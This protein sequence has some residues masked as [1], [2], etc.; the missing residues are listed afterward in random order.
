MVK[1]LS[2]KNYS[3]ETIIEV[4][5]F[6]DL[7]LSFKSKKLEILFD[8]EVDKMESVKEKETIGSYK[9][10]LLNKAKNEREIEIVLNGNKEGA[11]NEFLSKITGLSIKEIEKIIQEQQPIQEENKKKAKKSK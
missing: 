8:S 6:L 10:F 2:K 4:F 11:S 5:E 1:I 9:R 7:L 3:K